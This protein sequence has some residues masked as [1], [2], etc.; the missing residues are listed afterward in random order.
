MSEFELQASFAVKN[1]T[2][3]LVRVQHVSQKLGVK[4]EIDEKAYQYSQDIVG[5]SKPHQLYS[6]EGFSSF[7]ESNSKGKYF[8][9]LQ[10]CILK[11]KSRRRSADNLLITVSDPAPE[12]QL[13]KPMCPRARALQQEKPLQQEAMH[14]S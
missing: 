3:T 10:N 6:R 12:L 1:I 11:L 5:N 9:E 4:S 14:C 13:L 7:V 2:L 8:E